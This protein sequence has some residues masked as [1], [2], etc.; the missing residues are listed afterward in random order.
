MSYFSKEKKAGCV[1]TQSEAHATIYQ[2]N[3]I[4]QFSMVK[5]TLTC[6]CVWI[7]A[8]IFMLY[9]AMLETNVG[10]GHV[11]WLL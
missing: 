11:S 2:Y 3:Y 10:C 1:K 5:S 9:A 8:H 7:N 6:F 4:Y